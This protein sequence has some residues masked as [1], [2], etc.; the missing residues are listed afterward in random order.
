MVGAPYTGCGVTAAAVGMDKV[1]QKNVFEKNVLPIVKYEW[2]TKED[3]KKNKKE[4][5]AKIEK[6]MVISVCKTGKFGV[7]CGN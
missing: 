5:I 7:K 6:N 3:Y 2:F 1:I 4:I